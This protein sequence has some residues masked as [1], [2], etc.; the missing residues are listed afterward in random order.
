[1]AL[2]PIRSRL[3]DAEPR[4]VKSERA[5]RGGPLSPQIF[6]VLVASLALGAVVFA[7]LMFWWFANPPPGNG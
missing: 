7:A 2:R 4:I 5:A 1:M 3:D 6:F